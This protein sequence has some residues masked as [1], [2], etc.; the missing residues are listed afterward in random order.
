MHRTVISFRRAAAVLAAISLTGASVDE[1]YADLST[2]HN[3]NEVALPQD[4]DE[5][6]TREERIRKME[7]AFDRSLTKVTECELKKPGTPPGNGAATG[8]SNGRDGETPATASDNGHPGD[9]ARKPDAAQPEEA[10]APASDNGHPGDEARKPEAAQPEEASAPASDNG[11]PGD[12]ARKPEATQPGKTPTPVS[13]RGLSGDEARKPEATQTGETPAPVSSRGLS[14]DAPPQTEE[15]A[16]QGTG[17]NEHWPGDIPPADTDDE[18]A[19][20]LRQAAET[21]QHPQK[22]IERWNEY[23]RY[24]G[25]PEWLPHGGGTQK[26][27]EPRSVDNDDELARQLRQAA[28]AE[29]NPEKKAK[30]WREYRRYKGLP[31]KAEP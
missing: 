1:L 19:A 8:G 18:K 9:E 11:H 3:C 28:E 10:S 16:E 21:E 2:V 31:E 7:E 13:S 22:R 4:N 5:I 29:K 30:L 26:S 12:E 20:Q 15:P 6:L 17:E 25:L 27:N 14:G 23:R 24:K